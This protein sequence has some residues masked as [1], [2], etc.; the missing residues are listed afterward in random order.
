M[1]TAVPV[2]PAET[3]VAEIAHSDTVLAKRQTHHIRDGLVAAML[4]DAA[5]IDQAVIATSSR[6]WGHPVA[7]LYALVSAMQAQ[8]ESAMATKDLYLNQNPEFVPEALTIVA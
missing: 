5:V 8:P 2:G 4:E 3:L 7:S 1:D 6:Y